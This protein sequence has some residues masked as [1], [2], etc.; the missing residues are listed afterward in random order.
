MGFNSGFKG[1]IIFAKVIRRFRFCCFPNSHFISFLWSSCILLSICFL[2]PSNNVSSP[3]HF[4]SEVCRCF[5]VRCADVSE[6]FLQMSLPSIEG[7]INVWIFKADGMSIGR[8]KTFTVK[9]FRR[10]NLRGLS[11]DRNLAFTMVFQVLSTWDMTGCFVSFEWQ[12]CTVNLWN[13]THISLHYLECG[14]FR[15]TVTKG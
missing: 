5:G 1:L 6:L 7:L 2:K 3:S 15:H 11:S 8:G 4:W 12:K 13:N 9:P 10:R 14:K